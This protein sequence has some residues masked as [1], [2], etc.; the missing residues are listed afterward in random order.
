MKKFTVFL[1]ALLATSSLVAAEA[2]AFFPFPDKK[3]PDSAQSSGKVTNIDLRKSL[4]TVTLSDGT[5]STFMVEDKTS[6]SKKGKK[7]GISDLKK[8]DLVRI[9]YFVKKGQNRAHAINVSE[10]ATSKPKPVTPK[11][12]K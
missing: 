7:I 4:V 3:S 1:V 6:F 10:L 5:A 8:G 12:K 9:D 2:S 11:K